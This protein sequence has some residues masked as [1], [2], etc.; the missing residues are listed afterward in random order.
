MKPKH[1]VNEIFRQVAPHY[2]SKNKVPYHHLKAINSIAKCK[3]ADLGGHWEACNACGVTKVHYN[4]CGNRH[5]PSCQGANR[6]R[7]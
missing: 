2:L 1:T 4:S 3:T 5:C 6:E 7:C